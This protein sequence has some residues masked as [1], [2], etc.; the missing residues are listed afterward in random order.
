MTEPG[1]GTEAVLRS[2]QNCFGDSL[3]EG[4]F[5]YTRLLVVQAYYSAFS[6]KAGPSAC[7]PAGRTRAPCKP[8]SASQRQDPAQIPPSPADSGWASWDATRTNSC[9]PLWLMG[10]MARR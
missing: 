1:L 2:R 9:R 7:M 10:Q 3:L 8:W 6:A 5:A 4:R